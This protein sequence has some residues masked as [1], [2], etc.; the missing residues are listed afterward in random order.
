[1]AYIVGFTVAALVALFASFFKFDRDRSFYPTVLIV[2]ASYYVLFA[3]MSGSARSI[4]VEAIVMLLFVAAAVAGMRSSQWF[5]VAGLAL[6]GV[7]DFFHGSI[8]DNRGVPEF[9]PA[10]CLGYDVVAAA[11]MAFIVVR[12]MRPVVS[13]A[14]EV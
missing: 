3:T 6:H 14:V 8:I 7:F 10:W 12:R 11:C 5:V 2:V 1:M 4:I 13:E 9:W